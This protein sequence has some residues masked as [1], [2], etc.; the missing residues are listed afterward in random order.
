[1]GTLKATECV[2][3]L[4]HL[5]L[6]YKSNLK[7]S[8]IWNGWISNWDLFSHY[9][10]IWIAVT[11]QELL[12][13]CKTIKQKSFYRQVPVLKWSKQTEVSPYVWFP[14]VT[15]KFLQGTETHCFCCCARKRRK[16][17]HGPK[18]LVMLHVQECDI[19]PHLSSNSQWCQSSTG[20][21]Q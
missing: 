2:L 19:W 7:I 5:S 4:C 13:S 20:K 21:G 1:M 10:M 6:L 3:G 14:M 17:S 15:F 12:Y 16:T 18:H 11:S 9:E 8:D